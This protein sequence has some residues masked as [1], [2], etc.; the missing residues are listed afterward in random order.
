[1]LLMKP[2]RAKVNSQGIRRNNLLYTADELCHYVDKWVNIRWDP[3]DVT[4]LYVYDKEG[5]RICEARTAEP[6]E[7]GDR[8]SEEALEAPHKRKK[9]QPRGTREFLE[10]MQARRRRGAVRAAGHGRQAGPDNRPH[11][12]AESGEP[13]GGQGSSV[14]DD[15]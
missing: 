10:E 13:A 4:R 9:R 7:F 11:G 1:M 6:L 15:P 2:G 5:R 14:G 12:A 8:V 3:E